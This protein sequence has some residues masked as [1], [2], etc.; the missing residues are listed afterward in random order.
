MIKFTFFYFLCFS[1]ALFGDNKEGWKVFE[2][3]FESAPEDWEEEVAAEE[4]EEELKERHLFGLGTLDPYPVPMFINSINHEERTVET[5]WGIEVE[6]DRKN[7]T[8]KRDSFRHWKVGDEVYF[9]TPATGPWPL[10]TMGIKNR[11]LE[12]DEDIKDEW[13]GRIHVKR[14]DPNFSGT[15][16]IH[17]DGREFELG[18][19]SKWSFS[20]LHTNPVKNW[21]EGDHLVPTYKSRFVFS[22]QWW[23]L[24]LETGDYVLGNLK[25]SP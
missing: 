18:D 5:S 7:Y 25:R 20:W 10:Q 9:F 17:K 4:D 1:I 24:N 15:M 11:T 23:I 13:V 2:P 22:D 8:S 12:N 19:G 3:A 6:V 21:E 14:F 16:V